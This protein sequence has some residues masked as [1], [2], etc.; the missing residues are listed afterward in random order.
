M[1]TKLSGW[2]ILYAAE[3]D[4]VEE[5]SVAAKSTPLDLLK[6]VEVKTRLKDSTEQ[7]YRNYLKWKLPKWWCQSFL[8][9]VETIHVGFRSR[10]G[11][12]REMEKLLVRDIPKMCDGVWSPAIMVR[13]GADFL[14]TVQDA[15]HDIDCP[16]TVF[17]FDYDNNK[18]WNVTYE[19][20][21]GPNELS[22]LPQ[23]HIDLMSR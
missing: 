23:S 12:V 8:V 5:V 13:F 6:F 10:D 14:S 11:H 19:V 22:F 16:H 21:E 1:T 17:K 9:G 4:G 2:R 15:M 20:I 18:S 3:L 7:Q